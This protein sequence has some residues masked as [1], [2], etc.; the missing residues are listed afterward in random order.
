M[1][2]GLSGATTSVGSQI[3]RY[4]SLASLLPSL[5]FV[6]WIVALQGAVH[7]PF[8]EFTLTGLKTALS[9]WSPTKIG[10][11]LGAAL[12]LGFAVHPLMYATTQLLEG[13]WG[14]RPFAVRLAT[15]LA[16]RHRGRQLRLEHRAA[17]LEVET[18]EKLDELILSRLPEADVA[19][20]SA[21]EL[22]EILA[23]EREEERLQPSGAAVYGLI[24]AREAIQKVLDSSMPKDADRMLPTRLGNVLRRIEDSVGQSYKLPLVRIAPHLTMVAAPGRAAYINDTREQMDIAIRMTFYGLAAAVVTTVWMLGSGWWLLLAALPYAFAYIAYRGAVAAASAWGAAVKTSMDLDRFALYD[25]IHV[26]WPTDTRAER[27]R[28]EK[29]MGV[30]LGTPGASVTYVRPKKV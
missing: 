2:A 4:F 14:P 9:D 29:L 26:D 28:N 10:L 7:H 17:D 27:R 24:M 20:L 25:A 11:L 13:Y 18:E 15:M 16:L 12:V 22:E 3:G 21:E 6:T 19:G 23:A 5:L 8:G 1:A 30:L